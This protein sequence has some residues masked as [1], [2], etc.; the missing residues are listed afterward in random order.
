MSSLKIV[1]NNIGQ[2]ATLTASTEAGSMVVENLQLDSKAE[3]YRSTATSATVTAIFTQQNVSCVSFPICNFTNTATMR[4]RVYTLSG[5]GSP[6]LDTGNVLCCEYTVIDKIDFGDG[7]LNSN[8]FSYGG[9]TY[10]TVF[11]ISTLGE[12]TV[13]D[14]IDSSNTNG[15]VEACALVVGDEWSPAI[16]ANY[17]LALLL[18]DSSKH[19]RN[20]GG[21]LMTA[22]GARHRMLSFTL[23]AMDV[24]DRTEFVQIL[25]RNGMGVNLF[26]SFFPDSTD[27]Q[28]EQMYQIYGRQSKVNSLTRFMWDYDKS[29]VDIEEI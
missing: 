27:T 10:A 26:L 8:T 18:K 15:Y 7:A 13:I 23:G 2:L 22:R 5:D 25:I 20:D 19:T 28:Q 6:A 17:G 3:V 9:G 16:T 12:K 14:I 4:V 29:K 11:F 1:S 24:A 21:G